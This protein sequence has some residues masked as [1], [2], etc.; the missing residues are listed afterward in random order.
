MIL[1]GPA[2]DFL[3]AKAGEAQAYFGRERM[4]EQE[5]TIILHAIRIQTQI[6]VRIE[7]SLKEAEQ[8]QN[9]LA[10]QL[11]LARGP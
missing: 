2:K 5:S 8:L 10:K 6:G 4:G 3:R 7:M 11:V 9:E 1:R